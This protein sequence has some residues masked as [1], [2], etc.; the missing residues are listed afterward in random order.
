[1]HM[2]FNHPEPSNP[3]DKLAPLTLATLRRVQR[4]AESV[5]K[6]FAA[7]L[8]QRGSGLNAA[9]ARTEILQTL[10]EH[11][12]AADLLS[13]AARKTLLLKCLPT[14]CHSERSEESLP[15]SAV[16]ALRRL[17]SEQRKLV[18]RFKKLWLAR[19]K[20]EGIEEALNR[21]AAE[22]RYLLRL[23]RGGK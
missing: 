4:V 11:Q 19:S 16:S 3:N 12:L 6:T 9:T 21:F 1:M 8:K 13:F 23:A 7:A 22:E 18:A 20:P 5:S 10:L 14:A 15:S 2:L 17:I